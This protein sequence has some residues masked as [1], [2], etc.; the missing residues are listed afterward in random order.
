MTST[1][2]DLKSSSSHRRSRSSCFRL[3][4]L[5]ALLV[6]SL[7]VSAGA[8]A[9]PLFP[10]PAARFGVHTLGLTTADLDGDGRPDLI[11]GNRDFGEVVV[12]ISNG[13]GT[14]APPVVY[15][16]DPAPWSTAVG[17]FNEDGR[18]DVAVG[19]GCGGITVFLGNGDGTL[20]GG[21]D[22]DND[23]ASTV[24]ATG[25][26]NGDDHEDLITT[27]RTHAWECL[28]A[29][30]LY[31]GH[32]DGTFIE[33]LLLDSGEYDIAVEDFDDDGW[34]D[35]VLANGDLYLS[36]GDGSFDP[37]GNVGGGNDWVTAGDLNQDDIPDLVGSN[38]TG[39]V[40]W[41][42]LGNGD[43]TFGPVQWYAVGLPYPDGT[44]GQVAI[45]DL[46]QDGLPD[47]VSHAGASYPSPSLSVLYGTG[48][49]QFD[50]AVAVDWNGPS[51]TIAIADLDGD[52][53][54]DVVSGNWSGGVDWLLGRGDDTLITVEHET[55]AEDDRGVVASDLDD[56]GRVDLALFNET[57]HEVAVLLADGAGSFAP[58]TRFCV[59]PGSPPC[60]TSVT[61]KALAVAEVTGDS[62]LDLLVARGGASSAGLTVLEGDGAGSF[63]YRSTKGLTGGVLLSAIA[64]GNLDNNATTD[65]VLV[66]EGSGN[67][68]ILLGNGDGTFGA[69]PWSPPSAG[70]APKDLALGLINDDSFLDIAVANSGSDDVS[71]FLGNGD[72]SFVAAPV[73]A[74]GSTP[75]GVIIDDL[76]GDTVADLVAV[77]SN[78][79]ELRVYLGSGDGTFVPVAPFPAGYLYDEYE[80][81]VAVGDFNNDSKPDLAV[82]TLVHLSVFLGRGDGSF[83]PEQFFKLWI[84]DARLVVAD[85]N[86]DHRDDVAGIDAP[87]GFVSIALNQSGPTALAFGADRI[88]LT[89]PAVIGALSYDIYRGSLSVLVDADSDGL[90]DSGYGSCMTALDDDSRDTFFVDADMPSEG[91]G[92]F[93][94]MSVIDAGGDQ[95]L[96][97]TSAGLQRLPT[98]PCP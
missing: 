5:V 8:W 37:F 12:M 23:L 78:P 11:V 24:I 98:L 6:F 22:Y 19:E 18:T 16:S 68:H 31:L 86:L 7:L 61:P 97:T 30:V 67:V 26:F 9:R 21:T 84:A 74:A 57:T 64:A 43:G 29:T 50:D 54:E 95:G 59:R 46:D 39:A 17:D 25:D 58:P 88:T 41:V 66:D 35:F 69:P 27:A 4:A 80:V 15:P 49:G 44:A 13:D 34:D 36:N 89:W 62:H 1:F 87:R 75:T 56:D 20:D 77:H 45:A 40:L 76:D 38:I 83:E 63:S 91:G 72:G 3:P 90:P 51:R 32:G 60:P 73:V 14:F 33:V 65:A 85:F 70:T 71:V 92:F 53:A 94:L 2:L 10:H 93:Y 55:V 96:G 52:G 48:G 82:A 42:V 79:P 47:L 28:P 81:S